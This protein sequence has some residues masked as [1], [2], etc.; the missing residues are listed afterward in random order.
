MKR[1]S[2]VWIRV[3]NNIATHIVDTYESWIDLNPWNEI[4]G[5]WIRG[6]GKNVKV[7]WIYNADTGEFT[8]PE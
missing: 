1:K 3:N 7:G 8:T 6:D 2:A 5:V 4:P